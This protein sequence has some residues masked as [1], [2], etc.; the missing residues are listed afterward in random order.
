MK[1]KLLALTITLLSS[2]AHS[3]EGRITNENDEPIAGAKIEVV[4]SGAVYL[5]DDTGTFSIGT[6]HVNE[7]HVAADGFNHKVIHLEHDSAGTL[8]ITL[9][10]SIY[11]IVDVIGIPFHA[12]LIESAMP[13]SVLTGDDLRDQQAATLG[14]SLDKQLGVH[15]SFHGNVASTPIIRGLSGPRVKI[16]QNSLD[17][18]DV[19]RV[20]PDHSVAAEATTATQVE[21]LRG[22]A[23][24]F[25]GSGA[26]GGVVNVVDNSVPRDPE[27]EGTWILS[28][29]TVNEQNLTSGSVK[30]G[31][32]N[33]AFSASAF[34]RDSDDYEIP[35]EAES[36]HDDE[37]VEEHEEHSGGGT[38]ENT[39]EESKGFTVGASWLRDNGYIG[40]SVSQLNREYGIPGHGHGEE[41]EEEGEEHSEDEESV[42]LDLEQTRYQ[43]LSELD[44][45]SAWLRS[46]HT[47][48]GYTDYEHTEIEG[49]EIG[50][51]FANETTE[52]R[53]DFL[54]QEF[55]H[56]KGALQFQY[57][58][59]DQEAIGEEAFTPGSSTESI[60]IALLEERHFGDVLVQLGARIEHVEVDAPA[61]RSS[62]LELHEH[63]E[64]EEDEEENVETVAYSD[65][66]TPFSVSAG[67]V[68]EFT[69]GYNVGFSYSHAQ[70]ALSAAEMFSFGPHLGAGTYE[71]GALYELHEEGEDAH[72]ELANTETQL[73][74][75]NNID[76]SFRKFEGKVGVVVNLFY[77]QVDDFSYQYDTGRT[78]EAGH[79]DHAEGEG[80]GEELPIFLFDQA[81]AD[82]YGLE[83]ELAWRINDN[84]SSTMFTDFVRAEL[85]DGSNVPR[86]SPMRFGG[87]LDYSY[88]QLD[89]SLSWT[90]YDD[91]EDV[92]PT[93][94]PTEG[95]DLIDA[96]VNYNIP[97]GEQT[98]TVFVKGENLSDEEARVHTSFL[99]DLAPR[100]GRN[101]SIGVRGTF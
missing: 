83:A 70:R 67:A 15:S 63:E 78:I 27:L 79:D 34:Y 30:S 8:S 68:W 58:N 86:T 44:I 11:E 89:I 19:S 54:H 91:Q 48:I 40:V 14:D 42:Y 77:N 13:V 55:D 26:I 3:L 85:D 5:S 17:V 2:A 73:E 12:S 41:H 94:T 49:G 23:T 53:L 31:T 80:E 75:S 87:Q 95:Y 56:W 57:L 37:P 65:D 61:I 22:P 72:I 51:T 99:K 52:L 35:G 6:D 88:K 16:T 60:A 24:L 25:Y 46:V 18:S 10:R 82:L 90:R 47:R 81:D 33:F 45:D 101:F 62:E 64:G 43:L 98:F 50:T 96:Y 100:P 84:F 29:D 4:G 38:V 97:F 36:E 59:T 21:I 32:D 20:G 69:D 7:V 71:I 93:E 66:F 1:L 92:A 9:T 76:L 28:H 39:A 74:K